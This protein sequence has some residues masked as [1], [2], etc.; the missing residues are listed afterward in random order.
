MNDESEYRL[1]LTFAREFDATKPAGT[2]LGLLE[3]FLPELMTA[4]L[5]ATP[6]A[7]D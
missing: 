3:A 2:E 7:E 5:D 6:D 4:L 1:A